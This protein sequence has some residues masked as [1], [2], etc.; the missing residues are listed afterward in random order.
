MCYNFYWQI[1]VQPLPIIQKLNTVSVGRKCD[2][3]KTNSLLILSFS[4]VDL[5]MDNLCTAISSDVKLRE[6]QLMPPGQPLMQLRQL[7]RV[8]LGV[9]MLSAVPP[10]DAWGKPTKTSMYHPR[11]AIP[12]PYRVPIFI[13][14]YIY[15]TVL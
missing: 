14:I 7:L 10:P 6:R 15:S 5:L 2:S 1:L 12:V 9:G 11:W 3:R 8:P 4:G 13:Y